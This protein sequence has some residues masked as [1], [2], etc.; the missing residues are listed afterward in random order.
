[1]RLSWKA[2]LAARG[3]RSG[4]AFLDRVEAE[5][6]AAAFPKGPMAS[7]GGV[8]TSEG[9]LPEPSQKVKLP[10]SHIPTFP[11]ANSA[12]GATAAG[13]LWF[14][15]QEGATV[16]EY[17]AGFARA[18]GGERPAGVASDRDRPNERT[19]DPEGSVR[20]LLQPTST[21]AQIN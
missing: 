9:G 20:K 3:V 10:G 13:D 8:G 16:Q 5:A 7:S 1:M 14:E 17:K 12:S 15:W 4:A 19:A 2:I 6:A 21:K 18:L 11:T